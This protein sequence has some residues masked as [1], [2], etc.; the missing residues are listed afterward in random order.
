[1][2]TEY[3]ARDSS[4][5]GD[6]STT[7]EGFL[8]VLPGRLYWAPVNA[9]PKNTST[10]HFFSVDNELVYEPF[11]ADFGPLNLS[12]TFRYCKLVKAILDDAQ[13]ASKKIVHF[14][15]QCPKKRANAAYL[16]GAF[17][18]MVLRRT[19]DVAHKPFNNIRPPFLPFRD[20]TCGVCTYQCTVLDCL[21]GLEYAMRIKWF[22]PNTFDVAAYEFYEKVEHGD[23]NWVMPDKFLAF[24]GPSATPIDP[25]GF[26]AFT[27]EDYVPIF[28]SGGV[29]L[30]V[31]L[32]KKQYDRRR[33]TDHGVKHVD[34]YFLDGSCPSREIINKFLFVAENEPGAVAVHCKAG[35]G[36]TG[37]LIGLY[38][39]KHFQFPGRAY[40]GWNRI[41]RPGAILGPQQQFLTEMQNEMIQAGLAQRANLLG[42]PQNREE[43][44]IKRE[45]EDAE[46][47]EDVGQ[48][49]RLTAAKRDM[50]GMVKF[51]FGG[52]NKFSGRPVPK[53][54]RGMFGPQPPAMLQA[55]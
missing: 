53:P 4:L 52:N 15:G 39:Q 7:P 37:T 24:A 31:R 45:L 36:R 40:I 10:H 34:L 28:K 5:V 9:I 21:K 8:E 32:N 14:C 38:A 20:A 41:C 47:R 16:I 6:S 18:V 13:L 23:M 48:G 22:D 1:M 30:V 43:M 54:L 12:S 42:Q 11:F 35:L 17:Q 50:F 44:Q 27:P 25:D 51:G 29:S 3:F 26:P 19:A 33:F 2:N 46:R 49:D 55:K